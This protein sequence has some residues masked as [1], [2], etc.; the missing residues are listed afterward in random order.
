MGQRA[1][2]RTHIC[3]PASQAVQTA[4]GP[5]R[6][7]RR[8]ALG[9]QDMALSSPHPWG[10]QLKPRSGGGRPCPHAAPV[11]RLG[12]A[13]PAPREVSIP[14]SSGALLSPQTHGQSRPPWLLRMPGMCALRQTGAWDLPQGWL[15]QETTAGAMGCC[16][17]GSEGPSLPIHAPCNPALGTSQSAEDLMAP[18]C[19]VGWQ[20]CPTS[21]PRLLHVWKHEW[22]LG[23]TRPLRAPHSQGTCRAWGS[24]CLHQ[25]PEPCPALLD[26]DKRGQPR[27][28]SFKGQKH[29][30]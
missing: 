20:V 15:A 19:P 8:L 17:R 10:A 24:S 3:S 7:S 22:Q 14:K 5:V 28:N 25:S 1:L 21:L 23:E 26:G 18:E 4:S 16:L 11:G 13:A 12:Q 9:G 30:S 29:P 27:D 6:G 2:A